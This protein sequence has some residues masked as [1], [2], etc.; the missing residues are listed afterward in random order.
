M[1]CEYE[2]RDSPDLGGESAANVATTAA[3][4]S[5][6][7]GTQQAPTSQGAGVTPP[8]FGRANVSRAPTCVQ[9][10]RKAVDWARRNSRRAPA[11]SVPFT[12]SA[13]RSVRLAN[14]R[15]RHLGDRAGTFN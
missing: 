8:H 12:E 15:E 11:T 3:A 2:T 4:S 13:S 9:R 6:V 7:A 1:Q 5:L 14:Y 10:R